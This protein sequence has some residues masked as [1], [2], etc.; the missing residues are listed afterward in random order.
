MQN[1]VIIGLRGKIML[2]LFIKMPLHPQNGSRSSY[3]EN[4]SNSKFPHSSNTLISD[5]NF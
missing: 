2:Y 1:G 4:I 3:F 5:H